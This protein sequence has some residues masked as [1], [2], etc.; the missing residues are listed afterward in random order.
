MKSTRLNFYKRHFGCRHDGETVLKAGE[1][2][3]FPSDPHH[4]SL[5][6]A[7]DGTTTNRFQSHLLLEQIGIQPE[8]TAAEVTALVRSQIDKTVAH[9]DHPEG[10]REVATLL[11][12]VVDF[13]EEAVIDKQN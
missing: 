6:T 11:Q 3:F 4:L 8:M 7:S 10:Q 13:C 9:S 1:N 2:A 5:R 12:A